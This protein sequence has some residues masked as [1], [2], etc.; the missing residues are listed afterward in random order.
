[1]PGADAEGT[2]FST[3]YDEAAPANDE[4]QLS[5][6]VSKLTLQALVN[7]TLSLQFQ[8]S[9]MMLTSQPF[10]LSKMLIQLI[11]QQS[12]MLSRTYM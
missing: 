9:D 10:R 6:T 5:L 3:F 12:K 1:M 7:Q 11:P 2:V 4:A 8:L